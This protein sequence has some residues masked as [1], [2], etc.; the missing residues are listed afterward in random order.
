[1]CYILCSA[2]F[3]VIA[4]GAKAPPALLMAHPLKVLGPPTKKCPFSY[5]AFFLPFSS[6][7]LPFSSLPFLNFCFLPCLLP[8]LICNFDFSFYFCPFTFW[9]LIDYFVSFSLYSYFLLFCYLFILTFPNFHLPFLHY[10][11][12]DFLCPFCQFL[13]FHPFWLF[14]ACPSPFSCHV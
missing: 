3:K 9:L 5:L 14:V 4:G 12:S 7:H 11:F 10:A 6:F 13:I 8:I 1:M 2:Y